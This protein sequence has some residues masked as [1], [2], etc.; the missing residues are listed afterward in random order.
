MMVIGM[1]LAN[2]QQLPES[3][4]ATMDQVVFRIQEA[5]ASGR[6]TDDARPVFSTYLRPGPERGQCDFHEAT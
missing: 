1:L 2:L 6:V 5:T 4:Q 3:Q